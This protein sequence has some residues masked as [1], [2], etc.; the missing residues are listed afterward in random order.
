[1]ATAAMAVLSRQRA[2][3][4]MQKLKTKIVALKEGGKLSKSDKQTV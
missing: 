3:K 2:S 4:C 1:M